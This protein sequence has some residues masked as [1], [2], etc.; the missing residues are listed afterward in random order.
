MYNKNLLQI[1]DVIK[2]KCGNKVN[3][4]S[5]AH[6]CFDAEETL[7]A[8]RFGDILG[9]YFV[10][11]ATSEGG[12][13]GGH[14]LHDTYPDGWHVT[15]RSISDPLV[16]VSFYQTGCFNSMI[17]DIAPIRTLT[18]KQLND[19]LYFEVDSDEYIDLKVEV[20]KL[21]LKNESLLR[22]LSGIRDIARG[23]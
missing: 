18:K 19:L 21:N 15:C 7:D 6:G 2:I 11:K 5:I 14:N 23:F 12:G 20:A 8:D 1:G 4:T 9:E 17:T 3:V 16:K 13:I 10:F 22:K